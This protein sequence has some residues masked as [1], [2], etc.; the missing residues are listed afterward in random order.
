MKNT[1]TT[2]YKTVENQLK[3]DN[4][5][6]KGANCAIDFCSLVIMM[7]HHDSLQQNTLL[8]FEKDKENECGNILYY[9][10]THNYL[11]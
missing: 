4:K 10:I 9:C 8:A 1:T 3:I 5:R 2:G 11:C 6:L 7:N